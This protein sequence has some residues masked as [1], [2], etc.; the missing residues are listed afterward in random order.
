MNPE[1][2]KRAGSFPKEGCGGKGE[3]QWQ[4]LNLKE[5]SPM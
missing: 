4:N 3:V 5:R 2:G 1:K